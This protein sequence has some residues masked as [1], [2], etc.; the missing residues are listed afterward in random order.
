MRALSSATVS[1]R[2]SMD[3]FDAPTRLVWFLEASLGFSEL[4]LDGNGVNPEPSNNPFAANHVQ[5]TWY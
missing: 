2:F 1:K 5:R 3:E 4:R